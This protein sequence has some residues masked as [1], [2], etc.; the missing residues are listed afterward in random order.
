MFFFLENL[1]FRNSF[2]LFCIVSKYQVGDF[3][4]KSKIIIITSGDNYNLQ[5]GQRN[6]DPRILVFSIA[7][8]IVAIKNPK[9]L[10][11]TSSCHFSK[12]YFIISKQY[13]QH[14]QQCLK[15]LESHRSPKKQTMDNLEQVPTFWISKKSG[16]LYISCQ[17]NY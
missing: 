16:H 10:K 6:R 15:F 13:I 7:W 14:L 9:K 8:W 11:W 4:Q 2:S 5:Q 17:Q 12:F 1:T 3:K